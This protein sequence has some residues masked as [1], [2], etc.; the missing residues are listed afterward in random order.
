MITQSVSIKTVIARI[1][2]NTRIADTSYLEDFN[3]WIPE[4]MGYMRTK[5]ELRLNFQ[6]VPIRFHKGILPCS[7]V[8]LLAVEYDGKRLKHGNTSKHYATGHNLSK[9]NYN[10]SQ[11]KLFNSVIVAQDQAP[12]TI[13]GNYIWK[14]D[15]IPSYEN[16]MNCGMHPSNFYQIEMGYINTSFTDGV[17][18]LH[19]LEVPCDEDGLPLI[20]DNENYKEALYWYVRGKMIGC[21]YKDTAY[22]IQYCDEKFERF[23]A[24]AIAEIRYPTLDQMENR[25]DTLVRFIPPQNYWENFFRVD[26]AEQPY[27]NY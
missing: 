6:D 3:E 23:A 26:N 20:P 24:R 5:Q 19:Y 12:Y 27:I 9:S 17:V 10:I 25:Y 18:R 7:L 13:P 11:A 8:I 4:A 14:S 1:I 21:G 15:L 22:N 2:R 16:T